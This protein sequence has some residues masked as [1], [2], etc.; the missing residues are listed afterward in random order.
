[1]SFQFAYQRI[2][3]IKE[4][5]KEQAQHHYGEALSRLKIEQESLQAL[6]EEKRRITQFLHIGENHVIP[7]LRLVELQHYLSHINNLIE[8]KQDHADLAE[9]EAESA[10]RSLNGKRQEEKVYSILKEKTLARYRQHEKKADQQ[11]MDEVA[12]SAYYYR[13]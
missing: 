11:N 2:L 6:F 4:K 1:M 12:V 5:E 10:L 8:M 13:K 9:Q 7:V 3:D